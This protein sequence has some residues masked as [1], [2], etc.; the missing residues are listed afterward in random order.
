MLTGLGKGVKHKQPCPR[1][2]D[3][4]VLSGVIWEII[5]KI[6]FSCR[7]KTL[8]TSARVYSAK[9]HTAFTMWASGDVFS[10]V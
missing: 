3:R 10:Y 7:A 9:S 2:T 6:F 4:Q 8:A 1:G 5:W